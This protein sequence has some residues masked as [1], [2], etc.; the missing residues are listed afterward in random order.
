MFFLPNGYVIKP[1]Q[2]FNVGRREIIGRFQGSIVLKR[3]GGQEFNL[4]EPGRLEPGSP[5]PGPKTTG[6]ECV[7]RENGALN[8][9]WYHPTLT[10][11]DEITVQLSGPNRLLAAGFRKAR[12]HDTGGR[13]RITANGHIITNSREQ[14]GSWVALYVGLIDPRSLTGWQKWIG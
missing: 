7:I 8:C 14:D 13:I 11:R 10:G 12:P 5:W 3:P 6:L 9:T 1:L 2:D 4:E